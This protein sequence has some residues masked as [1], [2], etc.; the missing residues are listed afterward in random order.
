MDAAAVPEDCAAAVPE[1]YAA[2]VPEDCAA[3]VPGKKLCSCCPRISDA[4]SFEDYLLD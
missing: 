1:I 2:A 3:A 4:F